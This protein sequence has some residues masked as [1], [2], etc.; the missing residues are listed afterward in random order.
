MI[1]DEM[2]GTD[3]RAMMGVMAGMGVPERTDRMVE[4]AS[5]PGESSRRTGTK[6]LVQDRAKSLDCH[7]HHLLPP[8]FASSSRRGDRPWG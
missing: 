8:R 5:R 4:M 7:R 1:L 3:E 6:L 2:D